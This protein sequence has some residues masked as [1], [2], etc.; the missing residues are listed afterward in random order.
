MASLGSGRSNVML[1]ATSIQHPID[2]HTGTIHPMLR[3]LAAAAVVGAG[4]LLAHAP[5]KSIQR[6]FRRRPIPPVGTPALHT[7]IM[8]PGR[9]PTPPAQPTQIDQTSS[10]HTHIHT[11]INSHE[12]APGHGRERGVPLLDHPRGRGLRGRADGARGYVCV[13]CMWMWNGST[14]RPCLEQLLT[15]RIHA[16]RHS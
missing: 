8:P 7:C 13:Y 11:H 14:V 2:T 4:L 5:G 1:T 15:D 10:I 6:F 16:S 9:P 12:C 3:T